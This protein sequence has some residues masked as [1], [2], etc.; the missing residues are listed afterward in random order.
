MKYKGCKKGIIILL[1]EVIKE[2][3]IL[4]ERFKDFFDNLIFKNVNEK[5]KPWFYRYFYKI[6]LKNS[7]GIIFINEG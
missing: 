3:N 4:D 5:I 1:I 7:I 6:Y 2:N